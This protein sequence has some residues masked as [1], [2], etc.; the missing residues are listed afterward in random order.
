M[1]CIKS[2]FKNFTKFTG[3]HQC[4]SL[5][6]NKVVRAA[7]NFIEKEALAEVLSCE[8]CKS[9]N[10]TFSFL[11]NSGRCNLIIYFKNS[12][13]IRNEIWGWSFTNWSLGFFWSFLSLSI[14]ALIENTDITYIYQSIYARNLLSTD[15]L[16]PEWNTI[17][18]LVNLTLISCR[19]QKLWR[20]CNAAFVMSSQNIEGTP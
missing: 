2:A 8:F 16:T 14:I 5:F 19:G 15:H 9:F 20:R 3:K 7:S 13:N 11:M 12:L 6:I 1:F 18:H 10:N 17:G 4:Q